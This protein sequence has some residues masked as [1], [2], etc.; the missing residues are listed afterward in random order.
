MVT[1]YDKAMEVY[2]NTTD[3]SNCNTIAG[4]QFPVIL[5]GDDVSD[6]IELRRRA[7]RSNQRDVAVL[8][9]VGCRRRSE[10]LRRRW[11][12]RSR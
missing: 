12:P 6:V 11:T 8:G 7:H 3:W 10:I 4:P 1:G 5:E 2:S 9:V